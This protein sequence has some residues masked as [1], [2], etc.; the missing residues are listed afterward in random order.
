MRPVVLNERVINC[1]PV[2]LVLA[3]YVSGYD[4]LLAFDYI[5]DGCGLLINASARSKFYC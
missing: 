4:V 3:A 2:V 5:A 1:C